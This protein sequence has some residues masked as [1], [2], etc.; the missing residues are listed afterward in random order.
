MDETCDLETVKSFASGLSPWAHIATVGDD[1]KPDVVPVHPCWDG[2][3]LWS[4]LGSA[5]VKARNIAANPNVALH[6]QVTEV[7]DGVELWGTAE[8]FTDVETK[9]RLWAGVFDYDLNAFA[10][11][12]PENSPDT[13]FVAITPE[14]ALVLHQY[15]MRGL[16]RWSA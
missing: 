3:T 1:G 13:A 14:R 10:P 5:S 16:Q 8:V 9:R 12:G 6:W 15:G 11:G 2:D 4:M 7:G